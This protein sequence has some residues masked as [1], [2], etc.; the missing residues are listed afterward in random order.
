MIKNKIKYSCLIGIIFIVLNIVAKIL[1]YGNETIWL[2]AIPILPKG[3][4]APEIKIFKYSIYKLIPFVIIN[5]CGLTIYTKKMYAEKVYNKKTDILFPIIILL[6]V[7]GL[8]YFF[9]SI[10]YEVLLIAI[11]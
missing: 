5:I 2:N 8:I 6:I 4:I 1:I 10:Q 3:T 11:K 9:I 7:L